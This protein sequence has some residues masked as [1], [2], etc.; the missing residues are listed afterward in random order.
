MAEGTG[1][2]EEATWL[3]RLER[4]RSARKTAERLLET[5]ARE[6]FLRNRELAEAAATLET[7][8]AERTA[9][10]QTALAAADAAV[11]ARLAFLAMVSHELRTPLNSILGGLGLVQETRLDA[12]SCR[13]L[14]LVRGSADALLRLI[15]D[16]LDLARMESGA[17]AVEPSVFDGRS[18]LVDAVESLRPAAVA[19]G[20][21]LDL[22]CEGLEQPWLSSDAGRIRQVLLNLVSNAL[23]FT[24]DGGVLVVARLQSQPQEASFSDDSPPEAVPGQAAG[25][26]LEVTVT[27]TGPGLSEAD[28]ARLF[29]PFVRAGKAGR[30]RLTGTGLGL[31][32]SQ[33][34][35][36]TLGGTIGLDSVPGQG[37]TFRFH[38]PVAPASAPAPEPAL[39]LQAGVARTGRLLVVD[40]IATNSLVAAAHLRR[41]GHEVDVATSGEE[42]LEAAGLK[43]YD[44]IFMDLL[45]PG[46]DGLE[47]T[48]LLRQQP[49]PKPRILGLTA[50]VLGEVRQDCRR[51]GMDDV[52]AKPITGP[53]LL[54]ATERWLARPAEPALI[55]P[56]VPASVPPAAP[57]LVPPAAPV[58]P[59]ATA[60]PPSPGPGSPRPGP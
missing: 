58:T 42:A 39:P 20:L 4:E 25:Q 11:K 33:R 48:V 40:D 43:A 35:I 47:A 55:P 3:A 45:M 26:V 36:E 41:A 13:H 27:D 44:I 17:V 34:I 59:A 7:R 14:A 1:R 28:L 37:T 24:E 9:E 38:I 15:D 32:I 60:P 6:L 12:E 56:A 49:G 5:K 8:V 46:M 52:L 18:L 16:I 53:M 57:A 22:R 30:D 29:Q 54:A 21:A 23:K 2:A 50:S 51:V 31:A 10:L 19:K